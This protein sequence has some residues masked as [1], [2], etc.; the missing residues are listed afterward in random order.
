[1]AS[2]AGTQRGRSLNGV[3]TNSDTGRG[4][5]GSLSSVVLHDFALE[6]VARLDQTLS[7][8][9]WHVRQQ[10]QTNTGS[11]LSRALVHDHHLRRGVVKGRAETRVLSERLSTARQYQ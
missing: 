3:A 7:D 5:E 6:R 4:S 2:A 1:M 8:A 11:R 9:E 10:L